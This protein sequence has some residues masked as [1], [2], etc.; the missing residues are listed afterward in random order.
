MKKI[1]FVALM[2]AFIG[3]SN[4]QPQI[5]DADNTIFAINKSGTG[6]V[7]TLYPDNQKIKTFGT[8]VRGKLEGKYIEYYENGMPVLV[9]RYKEGKQNGVIK[10]FY[11]EGELEAKGFMK[12]D[13]ANGK[14]TFYYKDGTRQAIKNFKNGV[15]NG[16]YMEFHQN[17]AIKIKGNY[18]DGYKEGLFSFYNDKGQK[19]QEGY[20]KNGSRNGVWKNFNDKGQVVSTVDYKDI[21]YINP[22]DKIIKKDK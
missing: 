19:I 2:L 9:A 7:C 6:K 3:C 10:K 14:F 17:G 13:I 16:Y 11:P 15:Y 4:V 12:D 8:L 18:N 20:Y 5:K 21:G 1:F 22:E